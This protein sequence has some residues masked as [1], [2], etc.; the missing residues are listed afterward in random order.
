MSEVADYVRGGEVVSAD[1]TRITYLVRGHGPVI[2]GIHGGLGTAL[3]LMPLAERL[4]A[5]FTVVLLNLRGHGTS[6]RGQSEPHIDRYTEDV[7]AVIGSVGPIDTLFGYS[8]GALVGLETALATGDLI[9]HLVVYE[10]PLPATYPMTDLAWLEKM[11][12]QGRYEELILQAL[13][14]G[15]GGLSAAE[16]AGARS[17]PLWLANVAHAPTLLPT[18]RVLGSLSPTVEQYATMNA[19]TALVLGTQS[20]A[21]LRQGGG[22]LAAAVPAIEVRHLADQGHHFDPSLFAEA[23]IEVRRSLDDAAPR[24]DAR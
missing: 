21:H 2:V 24:A 9:P 1:G 22:Q 8:F 23:I 6:G 20:A 7:R 17:N 3:S 13:A 5:G 18:M 10:P 14:A 19:P 16:L 4:S 12:D 15:G 11:L